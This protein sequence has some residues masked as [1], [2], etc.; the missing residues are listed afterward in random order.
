MK[1]EYVKVFEGN[2]ICCERL[3][4][5]LK[6]VSIYPVIKDEKKSALLAGFGF[7]LDQKIQV[8]VRMD[9]KIESTNIIHILGI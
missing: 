8:F 3:I 2:S 6:S 7:D 1:H 5:E 4:T 9:Q